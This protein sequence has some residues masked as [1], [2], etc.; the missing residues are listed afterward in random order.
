MINRQGAQ[1][2]ENDGNLKEQKLFEKQ[3]HYDFLLHTIPKLAPKPK[4]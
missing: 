1:V 4:K 2:L 3:M